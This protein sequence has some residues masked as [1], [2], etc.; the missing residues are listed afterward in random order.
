MA[1]KTDVTSRIPSSK[2]GRFLGFLAVGATGLV[3]NQLAFW[4]L[5]DVFG[6][7]YLWGFL[8]ATQFSTAWNFVLLERYVFEGR[9]EGR[10]ARL[11]W[12]ALMNNIWNVASA[13][14]MYAISTGLHVSHL[15]ANWLVITGMTLVRFAISNRLIWGTRSGDGVGSAA[16]MGLAAS[17]PRASCRA[18][19]APRGGTTSTASCGS[20][21]R[22][23][24]RS[25]SASRCLSC[26]ANPTSRSP[27]ATRASVACAGG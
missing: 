17:T 26:M 23:R 27:S 22:R 2:G 25:W 8:L 21:P 1:T 16:A 19:A 18:G 14:V 5:T 10:W 12:Y 4:L 3:I 20:S 6:L 13:P 24:C 7:Y 11:G 15:W 9:R